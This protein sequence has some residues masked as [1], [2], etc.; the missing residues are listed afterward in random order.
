MLR[1]PRT[2]MSTKIPL[3]LLHGWGVN[4]RIWQPLL[5]ALEL[6][7]DIWRIDLPGYGNDRNFAGDYNLSTVAQHVLAAA[8]SRSIWVAWSLGATVAMQAALMAP[9]RFLK[10][11]LL[12]ATPK[13]LR[14][15]AWPCGM[16]TQPLTS[17]TQS[18]DA[19]YEKGLKRFLLLQT[20][21][22]KLAK[23]QMRNILE[24]PNPSPE[25]LGKSLQLLVDTD[26]RDQVVNLNTPTQVIAGDDDS[27]VSSEASRRLAQLI[28]GAEFVLVES[29]NSLTKESATP[30]VGAGHLFFRE[31]PQCYFQ[32]L[33][34]FA[35]SIHP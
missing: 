29:T 4:S 25:A 23:T 10:L 2:D 14:D 18:F 8:P 30:S 5:P 31:Q 15:D 34:R 9:E 33:H 35:G 28:P 17:L 11:Q 7:F 13:F 16:E 22:R 32:Q 21:Q 3:V 19:G 12:S 24:I 26:L 1:F 27:I 20:R 6:Q